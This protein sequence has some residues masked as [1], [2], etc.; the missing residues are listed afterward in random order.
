MDPA[1]LFR[2]SSEW[3]ATV[4]SGVK[5]DQHGDPTPCTDWDVAGLMDHLVG[6]NRFFAAAARGETPPGGGAGDDPAGAYRDSVGEVMAAYAAP[7]VYEQIIQTP[8]GEMPGAALYAIAASEQ[9]IHGWDLAKATGQ[10]TTLDPELAAAFDA[11]IR[12]N[13]DGAVEGGFYG[14]AVAVPGDASAGDKLVALVGRQP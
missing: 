10:D 5:A 7:G 9:L 6:S 8:G 13:I 1:D 11:M 4:F 3:A 14:P 12:P 2:R